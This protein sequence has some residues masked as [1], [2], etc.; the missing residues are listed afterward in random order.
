MYQKRK[1][2]KDYVPGVGGGKELCLTIYG[3][4]DLD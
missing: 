2:Q 3:K 4:L 1:F